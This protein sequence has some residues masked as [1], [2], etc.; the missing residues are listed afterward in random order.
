M[1]VIFSKFYHTTIN[2]FSNIKK[3]YSWHFWKIFL[4]LFRFSTKIFIKLLQNFS[5][6]IIKL[7]KMQTRVVLKVCCKFFLPL[8]NKTRYEFNGDY[9][10]DSGN[11]FIFYSPAECAKRSA[12]TVTMEKQNAHCNVGSHDVIWVYTVQCN[13][14]SRLPYQKY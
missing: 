11:I 13:S 9:F 6:N 12:I 5:L 7:L 4:K 3:K 14:M 1:I 2:Y 8:S 10:W